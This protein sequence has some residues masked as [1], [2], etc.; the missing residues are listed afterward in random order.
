MQWANLLKFSSSSYLWLCTYLS[1][2]T[3]SEESSGISQP[4]GDQ[5]RRQECLLPN[6][7]W[8]MECKGEHQRLLTGEAAERRTSQGPNVHQR[9]GTKVVTE[10]LAGKPCDRRTRC[11]SRSKWVAAFLHVSSH[12][13]SV[14]RPSLP[15]T[16]PLFFC[17]FWCSNHSPFFDS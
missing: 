14:S 6:T 9:R 5:G 3:S 11:S 12:P 15:G 16:F 10:I 7:I 13:C 8:C 1:S 17:G 2:Q 4:I